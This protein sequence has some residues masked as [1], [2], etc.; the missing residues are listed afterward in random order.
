MSARDSV[1]MASLDI[2]IP[3]VVDSVTLIKSVDLN[4]REGKI[5]MVAKDH[6][7]KLPMNCRPR[8]NIVF[9]YYLTLSP[10]FVDR[11]STA[12]NSKALE[13]SIDATVL[14]SEICRPQIEMRWR[15]NVDFLT[16]LNPDFSRPGQSMQRSS[17]PANIPTALGPI[18]TLQNTNNATK[19]SSESHRN[20]QDLAPPK[21][22]GI[23]VTFTALGEVFVG[24]PFRWDVFIINHSAKSKQ[25][26]VIAITKRARRYSKNMSLGP[27]STNS[28]VEFQK[29][30]TA[31]AVL[32]ENALY[33]M[34]KK[35][36]LET[37]QL[38][39]LTTDIKI[40]C[41]PIPT[42]LTQSRSS[43]QLT[44]LRPLH[45]GACHTTELKFLPLA[46]GLLQLEAVRF[47][48]VE[49]GDMVDVRNLPDVVAM[50]KG[51]ED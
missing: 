19:V 16:A 8:D 51:V 11:M 44:K 1:V 24:E 25:L 14:I 22:T 48:D 45:P 33:T 41:A 46:K 13:I 4:F 29:S 36:S 34:K 28:K 31:D 43:Y 20:V 49:S 38:I 15:T 27:S 39:C 2:E 32:D 26:S 30:Q 35:G 6:L 9:L 42:F 18:S 50:E 40:G 21:E 47:V 7:L 10:A 17:R 23:T 12:S 5:E 3:A 37:A